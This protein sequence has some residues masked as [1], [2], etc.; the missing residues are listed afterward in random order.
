[1]KDLRKQV[2]N[3]FNQMVQDVVAEMKKGLES[4]DFNITDLFGKQ[5]E[6]YNKLSTYFD[7]AEMRIK[8]SGKKGG[9]FG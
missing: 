9:F 8:G 7:D 4:G 5:S 2:F 3:E 1:M 6:H